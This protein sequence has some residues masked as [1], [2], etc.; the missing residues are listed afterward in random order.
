M[1][2][3]RIL[4]S[5]VV[6]LVTAALWQWYERRPARMFD[7]A[8]GLP[9]GLAAP[10]IVLSPDRAWVAYEVYST[11]GHSPMTTT[12]VWIAR[13]DG[14]AR[15]ELRLPAPNERFS[16]YVDGWAGDKLKVRAT[17]LDQPDDIVLLYDP[18]AGKWVQ[19]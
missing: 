2:R 18:A 14:S 6:L 11:A 10:E 9:A 17:L 1:P 8:A 15:T 16:T 19:Q 4:L 13:P 3:P 7:V 12:H 5:L